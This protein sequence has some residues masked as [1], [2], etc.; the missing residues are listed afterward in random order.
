LEAG[1]RFGYRYCRSFQ[2]VM[3][4]ADP[5][6]VSLAV[7]NHQ[8]LASEGLLWLC[9]SIGSAKFVITLDT[10]NPLATAEETCWIFPARS[11]ICEKCASK[12]VRCLR[13]GGRLSLSVE[14]AW[15]RVIPFLELLRFFHEVNPSSHYRWNAAL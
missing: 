11:S 5:N 12:R 2:E 4:S 13:V 8:D 9:E 1:S 6:G 10:D 3:E 15:A 7:E 14:A